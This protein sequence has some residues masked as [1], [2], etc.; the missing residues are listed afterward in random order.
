[1]PLLFHGFDVA[2][3]NSYI[4]ASHLGWKSKIRG[5]ISNGAHKEFITGYVKAFLAR[6]T[7]FETRQS[8]RLSKESETPSPPFKRKRVRLSTKNPQLPDHR[9]WGDAADHIK[10]EAPSQARCIMCAYYSY[11]AKNERKPVPHIARPKKWCKE[12]LDHLCDKHFQPYH[13]LKNP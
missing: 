1:M 5:G 10:T 13:T 2:R 6:A 4:A 11:K 9:F 3:V 7:T 12:C 8:R